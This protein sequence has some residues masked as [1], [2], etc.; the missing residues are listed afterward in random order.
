[1][2]TFLLNPFLGDINPGTAEGAKLYTKAINS[3][4]EK[5]NICQKNARDIQTFFETDSSNFGW[6]L[7]I[8]NIETGAGPDRKS[9]LT[10]SKEL[11]LEVV[12]K[13]A[14]NTW[15]LIGIPWET[16]LPENFISRE[17]DPAGNQ[18]QRPYF[19]RRTRS[20]MIAIRIEAS[21]DKESL[22]SLMLEK[23][24]FQWKDVTGSINN[25]GPT[26]LYLLLSKIN[27][28]VRVG[29]STLKTNLASATLPKFK[30]NVA[31]LLD[32]MKMQFNQIITDGGMHNDYTL[33]LFTALLTSNND[34]IL[35]FIGRLKDDWECGDGNDNDL[36]TADFLQ[37]KALTKFNNMVQAGLWK[38]SEDPS[39]KVFFA[40]STQIANLRNQIN[41]ASAFQNSSNNTTPKLMIPE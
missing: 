8:G 24:H 9:I 10:D 26:M 33:N 27:P 30:H 35:K 1:M 34:E 16:P 2:A 18:A 22:K 3:P 29:I 4:D 37:E 38:R 6:G 32:Y 41:S 7:L 17:I 20:L 15:G 12:Q 13:Y 11:N 25:D 21:L 19:F 39:T 28:S 36:V 5:L 23:K 40:L 31:E 14:R